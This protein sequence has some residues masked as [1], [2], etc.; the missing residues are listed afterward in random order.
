[1][2]REHRSELPG[3]VQAVLMDPADRGVDRQL[4]VHVPGPVGLVGLVGLV[5]NAAMTWSQ[6]P[7]LLNWA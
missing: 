3:H 1:M 2:A 6:V 4:P 7:S 5:S